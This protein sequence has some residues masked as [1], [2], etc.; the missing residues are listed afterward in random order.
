MTSRRVLIIDDEESIC[1]VLARHLREKGHDA[2]F[3]LTGGDGILA[4]AAFR[5]EVVILDIRLPD[6][7][8]LALLERLRERDAALFVIIITAFG[9]MQTTIAAMQRGAYDYLRKPIDIDELDAKIEMCIRSLEERGQPGLVIEAAAE[10][11]PPGLVGSSRKLQEIFKAIGAVSSSRTTVLIQGES[12]T[13]KELVARAIHAAGSFKHAPFIAINCG[14]L[15]ETLL[16]S[17]LFGHEKGAFTGAISRK[18]GKFEVAGDG[19]IF[20]DEIGEMTVANQVKLLR[21]LQ[22]R[23]FE[24]VGG[25]ETLS[26]NARIIAATI[27]SLETLVR[28]GKFREDLFYR[29]KVVTI[30]IPPLRER[31][32]DI[33]LLVEHFVKRISRELGRS[34]LRIPEETM[35]SL[36]RR[37]WRGN[38]RELE[39]A[40]RQALVMCKGDTLLPDLFAGDGEPSIRPSPRQPP[41]AFK[42]LHAMEAGYIRQ[43]LEHTHWNKSESSR[44]LNVSRPTLDRKIREYGLHPSGT[45]PVWA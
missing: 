31:Q 41:E 32:E 17:E 1:R 36:V 4:H 13:G 40:I 25:I 37:E 9:D 2:R 5:P 30:Q 12:G 7:N 44:I 29:L 10:A 45:D 27:P 24:R 43:V 8:G 35:A 39:N 28:E 38:V 22:E 16:A 26:T 14:V 23:T 15:V 21:A 18:R 3:A 19:T 20:L 33:P 11:D 42:D 34:T 6:E